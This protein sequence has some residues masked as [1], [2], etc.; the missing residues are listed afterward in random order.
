M[1]QETIN[2][3]VSGSVWACTVGQHD[4]FQSRSAVTD[5]ILWN[6]T[7]P[8]QVCNPTLQISKQKVWS[9]YLM[10]TI[11][12]DNT[13]PGTSMKLVWVSQGLQVLSMLLLSARTSIIW[14]SNKWNKRLQKC[15]WTNCDNLIWH[16]G[17]NISLYSLFPD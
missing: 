13:L 12:I 8:E 6:S 5:K 3:N 15:N 7:H 4:T 17:E 14:D 16:I 1:K 11:Y 10:F 2:S 9:L